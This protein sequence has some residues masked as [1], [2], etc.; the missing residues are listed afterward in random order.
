VAILNEQELIQARSQTLAAI[1]NLPPAFTVAGIARESGVPVASAQ[2]FRQNG[3]ISEKYI[4][5]LQVVLIKYG[6]DAHF[7]GGDGD[8]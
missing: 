1:R 8:E 5:R 7:R 4:A 2:S 6:L 3:S